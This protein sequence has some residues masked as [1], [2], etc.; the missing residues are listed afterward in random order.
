MLFLLP[1]QLFF[2]LDRMKRTNQE[3][4]SQISDE[5]EVV[6]SKVLI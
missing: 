3:L 2:L 4:I 1:I 5:N 6:Y